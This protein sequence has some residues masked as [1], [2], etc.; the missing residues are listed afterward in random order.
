MAS[1]ILRD[2]SFLVLAIMRALSIHHECSLFYE[3][4]GQ[5]QL[6]ISDLSDRVPFPSIPPQ[7]YLLLHKCR[8][9]RFESTACHYHG[10]LLFT[11]CFRMV[12]ASHETREPSV[13]IT[14]AC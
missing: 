5:E 12:L 2:A 3:I 11:P 9:I 14:E 10:H 7:K 6:T 13:W 1:R 4:C 8:R